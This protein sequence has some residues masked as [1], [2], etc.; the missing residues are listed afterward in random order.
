MRFVI[1][2]NNE[3]QFHWRLT[4]DDGVDLAVSP[5]SFL[6]EQWPP[7]ALRQ[8]CTCTQARRRRLRTTR[9]S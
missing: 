9:C 4:G 1:D 6:F 2:Q 7:A 3:G 5:G 8:T